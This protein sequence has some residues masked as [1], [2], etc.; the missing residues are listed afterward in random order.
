MHSNWKAPDTA[1]MGYEVEATNVKGKKYTKFVHERVMGVVG[2]WV[3]ETYWIPPDRHKDTPSI[4]GWKGRW[5]KHNQ[6]QELQ[7]WLP[8]PNWDKEDGG[9]GISGYSSDNNR[10]KK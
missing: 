5:H 8:L 6:G 2:D 3:G 10:G 9:R 7:G 4:G 1:P